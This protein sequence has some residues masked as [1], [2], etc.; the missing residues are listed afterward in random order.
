MACDL[1]LYMVLRYEV[2]G[3]T[4]DEILIPQEHIKLHALTA[5]DTKNQALAA[6]EAAKAAAQA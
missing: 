2:D 6:Q 3:V 5:E 1:I 4:F